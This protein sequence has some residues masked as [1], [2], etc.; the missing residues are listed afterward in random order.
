MNENLK[1]ENQLIIINE[2]N[3]SYNGY[4]III[5]PE[6]YV[7][8]YQR[9]YNIPFLYS[10]KQNIELNDEKE[11]YELKFKI[12][13]Y[14]NE[15]IYLDNYF[16]LD[17]CKIQEK[18]LIC[19]ISKNKLNENL[20]NLGVYRL[21]Y[22]IEEKEYDLFDSV[23]GINIKYGGQI[24][25]E[26]IYVNITK[27]LTNTSEYI[28]LANYETISTSIPN[29]E[30]DTFTLYFSGNNIKE[31]FT[32]YFGKHEPNNLLL[33]CYVSSGNNYTLSKIET[34]QLFNNI[35]YKYNFILEPV[36]NNE[37]IYVYDNNIRIHNAYPNDIDFLWQDSANIIYFVNDI[38]NI[39]GLRLAQDLDNLECASTSWGILSCK[40]TLSYF[41][42]KTK[43]YFHTYH[44]DKNGI[45][46]ILYEANPIYI[47]IPEDNNSIVLRI[48]E[49]DNKDMIKIGLNGTLYLVI[50]D[51]TNIFNKSDIEDISFPTFIYDKTGNTNLS[52]SCRL[53]K[54]KNE[55]LRMFCKLYDSF[56]NF[57]SKIN[58]GEV[59]FT[60][61]NYTVLI[62]S[63]DT[64]VVNQLKDYIY[65]LYAEKQEIDIKEEIDSYQMLFNY[66]SD[67]PE[68]LYNKFAL[69]QSF[70]S[71]TF[72]L[73]KNDMSPIILQNCEG[74]NNRLTCDIN[75]DKISEY[76][77]YS[78]EKFY[79]AEKLD[80]GGLYKFNSVLDITIN[81]TVTQKEINLQ[82]G[83]LL[84]PVIAKNE[85]IAY[86]TNKGDISVLTTDYFDIESEQNKKFK[87]LFK[88]TLMQIIYYFYVMPLQMEYIL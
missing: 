35:H 77:S 84:T 19:T 43:G 34:R 48:K 80:L 40:V 59:K 30:T 56:V 41:K 4:N 60:Y 67:D 28:G 29:I 1:K 10:E 54:P 17:Q 50:N 38:I 11:E 6:T 25:K 33:F 45:W 75:K 64:F 51:E 71:K 24:Q 49:E 32:R 21:Y 7:T 79:L 53:W 37:T 70:D 72:Y 23:L 13:S 22:L 68:K 5:F 65:F 15:I 85:F 26:D 18:E 88:K 16:I 58:L 87:C 55:K 27:L 81:Y 76:L 63:K 3:F 12:Y 36:E 42:N 78:G 73:Y 74:K 14:N 31:P 47:G 44:Q 66:E 20:R 61:K 46:Q 69:K 83:K 86:E 82:I 9:N 2:V 39:K 8:V 52:V 57:F 62:L